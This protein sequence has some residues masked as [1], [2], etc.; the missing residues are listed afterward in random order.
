MVAW[1][2]LSVSDKYAECTLLESVSDRSFLPN[3]LVCVVERAKVLPTEDVDGP[4]SLAFLALGEIDLLKD[5]AARSV[6]VGE[7]ALQAL[8][9]R[10]RRRQ[11]ECR[12]VGRYAVVC[13]LLRDIRGSRSRKQLAHAGKAVEI[14]IRDSQLS[15]L[16]QSSWVRPGFVHD[17][18]KD[19]PPDGFS[20][21]AFPAFWL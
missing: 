5:V 20:S 11:E 4:G 14:A 17:S 13:T 2:R 1:R 9:R 3:L 6:N 7:E 19:S 12:N 15:E 8:V 16:V 10:G 21:A 18:L